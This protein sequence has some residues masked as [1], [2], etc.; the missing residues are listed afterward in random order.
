MEKSASRVDDL[1]RAPDAPAGVGVEQ[2]DTD[3]TRIKPKSCVQRFESA[4]LGAPKQREN[5]SPLGCGLARNEGLLFSREIIR[6]ERVAASLN[7]FE[8]ATQV[9]TGS[10]HDTKRTAISMTQGNRH[11]RGCVVEEDLGHARGC[12]SHFHACE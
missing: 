7:Q 5:M 6:D 12:A 11:R 4:F 8:I 10:G 9:G 3:A 1:Q 2:I